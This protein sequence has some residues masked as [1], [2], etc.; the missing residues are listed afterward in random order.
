MPTSGTFEVSSGPRASRLVSVIERT[1]HWNSPLSIRA[2]Q[3]AH[4]PV[5]S[6]ISAAPQ[7]G[8]CKAVA[9]SGGRREH[10]AV[11]L[12]NPLSRT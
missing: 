8:Q 2:P 4:A 5:V 3:K 6:F 9:F 12:Q 7:R 1:N 11:T 10:V